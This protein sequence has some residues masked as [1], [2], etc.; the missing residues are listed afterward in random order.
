MIVICEIKSVGEDS[1]VA[2]VNVLLRHLIGETGE[3]Y[4][5]LSESLVVSLNPKLLLDGLDSSSW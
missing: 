3:N 2:G 1:F 5:N 4:E